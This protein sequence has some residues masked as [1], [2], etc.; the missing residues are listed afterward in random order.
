MHTINDMLSEQAIQEKLKGLGII[1]TSELKTI[2]QDVGQII[3]GR[4]LIAMTKDFT[5]EERQNLF[6]RGPE[7][8]HAY[9][10]E[11]NIPPLT[12]QNFDTIHDDTWHEYFAKL[13][14]R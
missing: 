2:M 13:K 3:I 9:L 12:Q 1:K 7:E 10:A 8:V 5:P 14:T 6:D 11:K 4:A